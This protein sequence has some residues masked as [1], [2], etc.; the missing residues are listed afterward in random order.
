MLKADL[1]IPNWELGDGTCTKAKVS[2]LLDKMALR[3]AGFTEQRLPL[4]LNI[5]CNHPPKNYLGSHT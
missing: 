4:P 5:G 3:K 2:S 1:P